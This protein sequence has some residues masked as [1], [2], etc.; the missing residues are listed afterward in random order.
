[1]ENQR[2]RT[3]N[4]ARKHSD[5]GG[6]GHSCRGDDTGG[7][8]PWGLQESSLENILCQQE[9]ARQREGG[10]QKAGGRVG[11][12]RTNWPGIRREH[13][14]FRKCKLF[15]TAGAWAV[16]R[17]GHVGLRSPTPSPAYPTAL[18]QAGLPRISCLGTDQ[19]KSLP[20]NQRCGRGITY[21]WRLF[22]MF[23]VSANKCKQPQW[24][25]MRNHHY[26]P[27]STTG[28]SRPNG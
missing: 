17:W 14:A 3:W 2:S 15:L 5:G 6:P 1:M 13:E 19:K 27:E 21:G 22:T 28:W 16:L 23:F 10:R 11:N 7:S 26:S 12:T 8:Q 20:N 25:A 9:L 4:P 24:P 18:H